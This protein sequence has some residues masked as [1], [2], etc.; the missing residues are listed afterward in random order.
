MN[1]TSEALIIDLV[2]EIPALVLTGSRYFGTANAA[3]DWDFMLPEG[4]EHQIPL[5]FLREKKPVY[6][7]V[8][9]VVVAVYYSFARN[10]HIQVVNDINLKV[11]AQD[12]LKDTG[13][14][15]G[16]DKDQQKYIWK[17]VVL[18]LQS[19]PDRDY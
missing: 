5:D 4:Y 1:K 10:C 7:E 2:R 12:I 14:L 6:A 11:H 16:V 9:P 8:D 18:A 19:V 3:S 17:A 13:A 15:L